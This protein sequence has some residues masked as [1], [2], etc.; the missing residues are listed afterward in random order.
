MV[1]GAASSFSWLEPKFSAVW[2]SDCAV[3]QRNVTASVWVDGGGGGVG[4]GVCTG[5]KLDG[6]NAPC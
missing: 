4:G 3:V 1:A 6:K 5:W 2:N